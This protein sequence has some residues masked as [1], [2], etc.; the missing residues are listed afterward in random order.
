M[1]GYCCANVRTATQTAMASSSPGAVTGTFATKDNI[2]GNTDVHL[3]CPS[4]VVH[5]LVIANTKL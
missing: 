3:N 5:V 1:N 2:T 4:A